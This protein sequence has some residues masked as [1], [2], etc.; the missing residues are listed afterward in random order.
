MRMPLD[1]DTALCR[2]F[3]SLHKEVKNLSPEQ[4]ATYYW[5]NMKGRIKT[6][7]YK[8]NNIQIKWL[9]EDFIQWFTS[10]ENQNRYQSIIEA[11]ETPSI[12]RI[13]SKGNYEPSNCR[14]IPNKLNMALGEVNG[15]IVRMAQLQEYLKKNQHWLE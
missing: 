1:D 7:P 15:L 11:G 12:D 6:K 9:K 10:D 8:K 5:N 2:A 4:I 13:N 14:I 3:I